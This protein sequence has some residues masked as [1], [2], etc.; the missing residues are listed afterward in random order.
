VLATKLGAADTNLE[1][2]LRQQADTLQK[3]AVRAYTALFDK[4]Q[5]LMVPKGSGG[6]VSQSFAPIEWGRGYVEGNAWHHSFPPYA[7]V[8]ATTGGKCILLHL[9]T[10]ESTVMSPDA[11]NFIFIQTF[12]S[13]FAHHFEHF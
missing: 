11:Y 2:E 8:G 13:C 5:G 3:R 7:L 12:M 4:R 1:Q 10:H 6:Q 9:R